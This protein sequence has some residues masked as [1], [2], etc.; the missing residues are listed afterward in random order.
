MGSTR[1]PGKILLPILGKP[2]LWHIA[3]RLTQVKSID[4]IVVATSDTDADQVVEDFCNSE[5]IICFRG[6][7]DDVLDRF[8]RAAKYSKANSVIRVTGDCPLIDAELIEELIQFYLNN[9]FD[10]CGIATGAGVANEEFQGR[11]PDGLDAEIF[12]IDTLE[13]ACQEATD[14]L[15]REHVTPY[16]WK[17]P[18]K[19]KL[20]TLR[21]KNEDYS[22]YRLTLDKEEDYELIKWIYEKL[23]PQNKRFN[24]LAVIDLLKNN[25]EK[26]LGNKPLIGKEDYDE[27]WK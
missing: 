13:I 6:S 19:F 3:Q 24:M 18:D 25:S 27:F 20:G 2:I 4:E 16:I 22:Q 8:Y 26:T 9:D 23:Y 5:S 14:P 21:S 12:N 7:E 15:H 17:N 11:Y 10:H 1:L